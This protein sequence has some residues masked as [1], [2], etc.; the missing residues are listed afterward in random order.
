MFYTDAVKLFHNWDLKC[1]K[2]V[3]CNKTCPCSE[4]RVGCGIIA[5]DDYALYREM[6]DS[7]KAE[8]AFAKALEQ[9][10]SYEPSVPCNCR[11]CGSNNMIFN[12]EYNPNGGVRIH[13]WCKDCHID[14][15]YVTNKKNSHKRT[16]TALNRW[17]NDVKK[18]DGFKCVVCG[19]TEGIEAHHIIPVWFSDEL[20]YDIGNGVTLCKKHHD[21]VHTSYAKYR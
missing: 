5:K 2:K 13:M 4:L 7:F 17:A 6:I 10:I 18:R 21:M 15:Y 8:N 1:I 3:N 14:N 16:N 19:E 9:A 12:K 20:K 11:K